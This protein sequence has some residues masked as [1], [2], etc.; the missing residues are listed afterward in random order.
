MRKVLPPVWLLLTL[1]AMTALH[2][3]LPIARVIA[4][5]YSYI[6]ALFIIAGITI[7][8]LGS[9]MFTKAGTPVIPFQKSTVLVTHGVF[10]VTRN[11][12][13]AGMVLLLIGAGV[14]FGT[15]GS[16]LP[17]PVFVWIIHTT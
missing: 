15:V 12:M 7:A 6:G 5:P 16:W 11:P 10:S 4:P 1:L 9:R 2:F 13:Y 14:L 17:I 3:W 8:A